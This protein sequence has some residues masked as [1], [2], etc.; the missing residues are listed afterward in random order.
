MP[1]THDEELRPHIKELRRIRKCKG[2]PALYYVTSAD[3]VREILAS[4][5]RDA[6]RKRGPGIDGVYPAGVWLS[7]R[8]LDAND[9][10][11]G[12]S[13]VLVWFG[14]S[15]RRLRV[16]EWPEDGQAY[17]EWL[18]PAAFISDFATVGLQ[19]SAPVR[20]SGVVDQTG[21]LPIGI[22]VPPR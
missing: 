7:N 11:I 5:F 3:T 10:A 9:G 8:P 1:A 4:G 17:R 22:N 6:I 19:R 12:D 20:D 13:V 21:L 18:I 16:F 15:W 14:I 2:F